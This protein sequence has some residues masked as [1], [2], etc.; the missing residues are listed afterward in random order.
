MKF[1]YKL[2]S[3]VIIVICKL[4]CVTINTAG[5]SSSTDNAKIMGKIC[6]DDGSPVPFV[7]V[8]FLPYDNDPFHD[9][10]VMV[11]DTTDTSGKYE[12]SALVGGAYNMEAR[13]LNSGMR[14][15]VTSI[16]P[17]SG[18][19]YMPDIS[20]Q[21]PCNITVNMGNSLSDSQGYVYISGTSFYGVVKN[22]VA[23]IDSV[24]AGTL[25]ALI[26]IK[27]NEPEKIYQIKDSF[28]LLPGST[29]IIAD[30]SAWKYSK[31]VYLNTS[32]TG[33]GIFETVY[34]FPVLIRL[35]NGNFDFDLAQAG[36]EDIRF[37]KNDGTPLQYEIERWSSEN[38]K[39][40]I[41]VKLD[42][43]YGNHNGAYFTMYWGNSDVSSESNCCAAFDTSCGFQ[44]VWHLTDDRNGVVKDATVNQYHGT[45]FNMS[46]V[47]DVEGAVGTACQFDG[48]SSYISIPGTAQSSL[49]FSED[50]YYSMSL[51]A[52]ADTIDSIYH[53]I[54]GKGHEQY[55]M[56]LKCFKGDKGTWE[57]VE[58]QD[59]VGW[60]YTEDSIVPGQGARQ[61]IYLTAVRAGV[62]QKFYINGEKVVEKVALMSG[63][64]SRNTSDD[65]TIGSYGRT[66]EIPYKQ[67]WSYF[68][69]KIDE[70]RV[71]SVPLSDDWI[72]LCYKN[73]KI[74]DELVSFGE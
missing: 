56:Q 7:E 26:Y 74:D 13:G 22:G 2:L 27:I 53:A 39:A 8:T 34:D 47:Y 48:I 62:T 63:E 70:V 18:F 31:K 15:I 33:A 3:L 5:G 1:P 14:A 72:L 19:N 35:T 11:I 32:E 64:Y 29:E 30:Y 52:Y 20:L 57:F 9:S 55:Y 54:A 44:A 42:T 45:A 71:L 58:F 23:S 68:K 60:E 41:W 25:P 66:V 24:P 59:Q 38:K 21:K 50:G 37:K 10:C 16:N 49:N 43:I 69:G 6:S 61:W 4:S 73:Q 40:E 36:G 67:G 65:F 51:W 28:E 46:T 12:V 17:D